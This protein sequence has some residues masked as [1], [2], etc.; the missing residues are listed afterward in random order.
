MQQI[1]LGWQGLV[2]LVIMQACEPRP[3]APAH[4]PH[5]YA[6][7]E[8]E[9]VEAIAGEDAADDPAIWVNPTDSSKSLIIGTNKLKGLEVYDLTGKRLSAYPVGRV[10]NVD[11]RYGFPLDDSTH[12][13]IVAGSERNHNQTLVFQIQAD[14][15]LTALGD[16]IASQQP[17]VYGFCLYQS[18]FTDKFYAFINDKSGS[19]E[20][21]ELLPDGHEG[22]RGELRRTFSV[23][24]QPE[25]MVADDQ[26]AQLYVG[27]EGQ[28]IWRFEAEPEASI[29]GRLIVKGEQSENIA[30]DIE[31]LAIYRTATDS[32]LIASS[33]GN[34][35]YAVFSMTEGYAYQGSF[36]VVAGEQIDGSEET[37]GLEVCAA[38]LGGQ[39]AEGVFIVQDGY[40]YTTEGKGEAQNFKLVPW[41]AIAKVLEE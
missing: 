12:V 27:E 3:E 41:T 37:D 10:N 31:G 22:I 39:Y 38:N 6:V 1:R 36:G 17:E 5:V 9:P 16:G 11:L 19:I 32:L 15:S 26:R 7:M 28:G 14:G 21:W 29:E 34:H 4:L 23:P 25:G 33:Q 24:S 18:P 8:T 13:D 20:Q 30:Y 40:N 35:S 2:L